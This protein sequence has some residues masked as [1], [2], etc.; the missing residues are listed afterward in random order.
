M[1]ESPHGDRSDV[2]QEPQNDEDDSYSI[3]HGRFPFL[4]CCESCTNFLYRSLA[5][6]RKWGGQGTEHLLKN[7]GFPLQ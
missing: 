4:T 3:E 1:Y 2:A 5:V 6:E 7:R